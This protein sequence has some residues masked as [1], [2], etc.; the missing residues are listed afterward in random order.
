M[1]K[2]VNE[3]RNKQTEKYKQK[4]VLILKLLIKFIV[5]HKIDLDLARQFNN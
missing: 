4:G 1:D 3:N 5:Q 2:C